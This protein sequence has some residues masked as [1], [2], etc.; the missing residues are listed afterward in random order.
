MP[1]C[2][3]GTT[4]LD[5]L[6]QEVAERCESA[7]E[8]LEC[9]RQQVADKYGYVTW[10]QMLMHLNLHDD[11]DP[12]RQSISTRFLRLACVAFHHTDSPS[13]W[14]QAAELLREQPSLAAES[15][16]HAACVG[17]V[18]AV[19][20]W[21]QQ[22]PDLLDRH[23]GYH[24]WQPLMYACYSRLDLPEYSTAAVARLL[25]ESGANPNA[26]FM[27]GGQYRFTAL[28]GVFGEGENGAY[29]CPEHP[30]CMQL[31]RALLEAGADPNDSQ[32]LYDRMFG[33][34]NACLELLLEFGLGPEHRCNWLIE[35]NGRLVENPLQTLRYQL[36]WALGNNHQKRARLLID[37]GADLSTPADAQSLYETAMQK[38]ETELAQ[39]L[40]EQG[41]ERTELTPVVRFI[42]ACFRDDLTEARRLLNEHTDLLQRVDEHD[43]DLLHDTA[44]VAKVKPLRMMLDLGMNP[45]RLT[46]NCPLHEAA[47]HGRVE[48]AQ[49]LLAAGADPTI[50]DRHWGATPLQWARHNGRMEFLKFMTEQA[51]DIFDAVLTGHTG[52]IRAILREHP[53]H[54]NTTLGEVRKSHGDYPDDWKTPLALAV[55][56]GQ[57]D[58]A[59]VLIQAGARLDIQS[60]SG[61]DPHA[62]AVESENASAIRALLDQGGA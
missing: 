10:R 30:E 6:N 23:G 32:A 37:H 62:L 12:A 36:N 40:V 60:P 31:A 55:E 45:N 53:Q 7:G 48:S 27:W 51:I 16:H 22:E 39:Y 5:T 25:L 19:R 14:E 43:A 13:N 21:L 49:V 18:E 20:R 15:I 28:T 59:E 58:A 50:R 61:A 52:R 34:G 54:A 8:Q 9:A 2:L 38:G 47:W 11:S 44:A 42:S 46:R 33:P 4:T 57:V 26:H 17:D 29:N 24:D 35:Q 56:L 1:E 41:A 3:P